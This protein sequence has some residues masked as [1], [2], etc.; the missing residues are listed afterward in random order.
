MWVM[1][2]ANERIGT[3]VVNN[4]YS[5]NEWLE[6]VPRSPVTYCWRKVT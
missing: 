6:I 2:K 4:R 1:T 5:T 3:L